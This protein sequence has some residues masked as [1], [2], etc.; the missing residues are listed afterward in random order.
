MEGIITSDRWHRKSLVE[1]SSS[2]VIQCSNGALLMA[3]VH[4]L[5]QRLY[6]CSDGDCQGKE[7]IVSSYNLGNV[8]V[9]N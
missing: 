9:S 8:T 6:F 2:A 3:A 7:F 5:G 4:E 1:Q